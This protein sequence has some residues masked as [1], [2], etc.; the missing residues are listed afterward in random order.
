MKNLKRWISIGVAAA[1]LAG[2]V[3]V[4]A[5][6]VET[7]A[8][9]AAV[10]SVAEEAVPASVDSAAEEAEFLIAESDAEAAVSAGSPET[11]REGQL[12]AEDLSALNGGL[13]GVFS[14]NG[15][16]TFVDG[17]CTE[18]LVEG[19]EDAAA[20]VNSMMTLIG[21]D[22]NTEFIPWRT[23]TDPI[24]N[25]YYIF[26]QIYK[27]TTVCGG[28]VKVIADSDGT[29]IGLTSSVE[30]EMPEVESGEEI[31]A[32]EAE[33]IVAERVHETAGISFNILSQFTDRV[34]LPSMLKFDVEV[35]DYSCRFAW[36]VYTDN[37]SGNVTTGSDLPYLAHYV[38]MSG[39]YLYDMPAIIPDD[40]AG[41]TGYDA[42]YIFEFMEPVEYTGYV[43][44]SDGSEKEISVTLMRDKRT[45][46]YYLGNI[47]RRIVVAE[48]YDFL[49][50]GGQVVLESNP[51]NR[52][53]DQVGLLAL[54]NY[55]RAWD[56]YNEIGWAGGD[57]ERTPIVIL[58]NYCDDHYNEVNNACYVGKAY[59][60]QV[61]LTSKIN[62]FSQCL[63]VIAHEFTHCVTGSVMTYNAYT[64]DYGAI[65]EAMSDI[66]GKN[67][68]MMAGDAEPDN[69]I[70]GSHSKQPARSMSDPHLF[71]QPEY[72]WDLY[73]M[74]K[75][76]TPTNVNDHGGVHYNSSLLNRVEYLLVSEGGMT[77][78]EARV[79]WIMTDC[80]MV[81]QT[82]YAQ[83]AELLPWV[84][85][86][87][88]M[89]QYAD[90]LAAA[91]KATRLGNDVMP[92][93]MD[94]DR[95]MIRVSLPATEAFDTGNWVM[96][97]TSIKA[98]ELLKRI[99]T[100]VSQ[101][102]NQ[103][104]SSLPESLQR[105]IEDEKLRKEEM[106]KA[107][108]GLQMLLNQL[109]ESVSSFMGGNAESQPEPAV[110]AEMT[111]E[112]Q[113]ALVQDVTKWFSD[114]IREYFFSSYGSAGQ[115]GSTVNM[116]VRPG[117]TIPTLN[118]ATFSEGSQE[119]DQ[120]AVAVYIHGK[121]Y[122]LHFSDFLGAAEGQESGDNTVATDLVHE[123]M[124][125][126]LGENLENLG[127]IHSL[128]DALDL[129]TVDIKGGEVLELSSEGLDQIVIPDP[130]PFEEKSFGTIEPGKKS[131]PR[132]DP[133]EIVSIGGESG[134]ES[135]AEE[136]EVSD[137]A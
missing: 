91:I 71:G 52:E 50:G 77:L 8:E 75:V 24:G 25:R 34:I 65:N 3:P 10:E 116:V 134:A 32:E 64:N 69:W 89:E 74:A 127:N 20:V 13:E 49:Y 73:Y 100:I 137:A 94:D 76:E 16:V 44:L 1:L 2:A 47:E 119:P 35:E 120:M 43:D 72:S 118:H 62:D 82:D 23:I 67:C 97:V 78:D 80:A 107:G 29:M 106:E 48:C 124:T 104:Y 70:L 37:P 46:M 36:V 115:D 61:F 101:L 111:E 60:M 95:A 87:A 38:S 58:N 128:D 22:A 121:W 63:D 14:H 27:G 125:D 129:I 31:S 42:S 109:L 40:E 135:V 130:T 103:D 68:E 84:L 108:S 12:T 102:K 93:T 15:R 26:Q 56:Y 7:A 9:P 131:R 39:E 117:R 90:T 122:D 66:Q 112:E 30:S 4:M 59:G 136:A 113:E 105:L 19:E 53:W 55:C 83:L 123:L 11:V 92:E 81:P 98:V 33:Q 85:K 88:G 17:T 18:G 126:L 132:E 6:S 28:A 133:A 99:T 114:I 51:D 86:T 21:A 45:G 110:K 57:G 41:R 79:F 96:Q 54:Y 5:E